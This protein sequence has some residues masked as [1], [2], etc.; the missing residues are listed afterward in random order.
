MTKYLKSALIVLVIGLTVTI[1]GSILL[2][3]NMS[4]SFDI[5][6][7]AETLKDLGFLAAVL[8]GIVC[9]VI[10]VVIAIRDKE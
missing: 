6:P 7:L 1:T 5:L 8:S 3:V 9:V 2:G 10:S 4:G